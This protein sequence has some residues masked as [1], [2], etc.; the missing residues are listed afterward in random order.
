MLVCRVAMCAGTSQAMHLEQSPPWPKHRKWKER[1]RCSVIWPGTLPLY[2]SEYDVFGKNLTNF[3]PVF[4]IGGCRAWVDA[5]NKQAKMGGK[6]S[7]S[8]GKPDVDVV[9]R[10]CD[11]RV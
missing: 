4:L 5:E 6:A 1:Y 9:S 7:A 11:G 8:A 3:A 2:D 10:W